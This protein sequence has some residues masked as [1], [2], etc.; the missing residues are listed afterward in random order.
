MDTFDKFSEDKLPP[1][2][3]DLHEILN[4]PDD[5]PIGFILEVDL[6]Y[7]EHLHDLHA[8]FPLA[9]TKEAISF[10]WLEKQLVFSGSGSIRE[11][12]WNRWEQGHFPQKT[13]NYPN[14]LR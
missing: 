9:P 14:T 1:K 8:D 3:I 7:P 4:T 13:K 2:E 5:S 11:K 6:L 12:R 10:F